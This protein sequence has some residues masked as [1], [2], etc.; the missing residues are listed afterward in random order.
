MRGHTGGALSLGRGF[1]IVISTKQKLN[2][3][4]STET[5]LLGV[6]DC[7]PAVCWTRYFLD[8]QGYGVKENLVFQ[9]NQSAILLE[10]NGM[11]SSGKR[12]KHLNVRY[13]FV[14]D[15]INKGELEV[16]WCPTEDMIGDF[17]T[18]LV[19]GSLFRKFR[20]MIMGIVPPVSPSPSKR[21]KKRGKN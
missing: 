13:F 14:T 20:D 7:M 6:D 21:K 4:S 16:G 18:K 17:A 12:T 19:Q 9:D 11:A 8:A 1:L 5:K 2:T 15:R 10:T 3:R